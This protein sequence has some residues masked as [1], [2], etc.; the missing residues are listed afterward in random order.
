M[1]ETV[2]TVCTEL[3]AWVGLEAPC[4]KTVG[5]R[6]VDPKLAKDAVG[7]EWK[8]VARSFTTTKTRN[9]D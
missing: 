9:S 3:A 7:G 4:R 2:A 5:P 6:V 1:K 8:F